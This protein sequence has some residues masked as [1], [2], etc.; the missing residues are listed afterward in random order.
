MMSCCNYF[1]M[2][3]FFFKFTAAKENHVEE[4]ADTA[5]KLLKMQQMPKKEN[6]LPPSRQVMTTPNQDYH[7]QTE[8]SL[9]GTV[10]M[11]IL[12]SVSYSIRF[13]ISVSFQK[14][15]DPLFFVLVKLSISK[16]PVS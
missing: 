10:C 15:Q 4:N 5:R 11:F 1:S 14:Q 8:G 3:I 6:H 12:G 9:P 13:V 2:I 7:E 16:K